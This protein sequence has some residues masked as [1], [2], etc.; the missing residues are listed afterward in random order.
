MQI[1]QNNKEL[2]YRL[3]EGGWG[4]EGGRGGLIKV[5]YGKALPQSLTPYPFIYHFGQK[6]YPFH[7]PSIDI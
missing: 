5:L 3:G 7:K 1:L 4:G 6:R 2:F